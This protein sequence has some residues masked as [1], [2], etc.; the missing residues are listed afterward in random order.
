ML[1]LNPHCELNADGAAVALLRHQAYL[2]ASVPVV[3]PTQ[4]LHLVAFLS[5]SGAEPK[6]F[7]TLSG[8]CNPFPLQA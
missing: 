4:S 6:T 8:V 3:F 1:A 5:S 2:P 7:L